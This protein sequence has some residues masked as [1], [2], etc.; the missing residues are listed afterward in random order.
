M[1]SVVETTLLETEST[2]DFYTEMTALSRQIHEGELI[3]IDELMER[4]F[5]FMGNKEK[6][7]NKIATLRARHSHLKWA[8]KL[9]EVPEKG[10]LSNKAHNKCTAPGCLRIAGQPCLHCTAARYCSLSC[11]ELHWAKEHSSVCKRDTIVRERRLT[12]TIWPNFD[13]IRSIWPR[14]LSMSK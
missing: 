8:H 10:S 2:V 11:R 9:I 3:Q 7:V 1:F 4:A 13:S 14:T 6:F 5:S 12:R